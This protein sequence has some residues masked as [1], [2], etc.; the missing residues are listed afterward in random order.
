MNIIF[1][2]QGIEIFKKCPEIKDTIPVIVMTGFGNEEYAVKALKSGALDYIVK[3]NEIFVDIPH[4]IERALREWKSLIQLK[5]KENALTISEEKFRNFIEFIPYAFFEIDRD[6]NINYY[7]KKA[8]SL[9]NVTDTE[10]TSLTF[11]KLFNENG[12]AICE[13]IIS[14]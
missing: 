8:L 3:S 12:N 11:D 1:F 6:L 2:Y 7:N 4:I 5:V 9:L 10:I 13:R 14:T